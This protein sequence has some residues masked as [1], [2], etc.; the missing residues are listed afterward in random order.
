[1]I[2]QYNQRSA[3]VNREKK[4]LNPTWGGYKDQV[5][6][7]RGRKISCGGE[8]QEGATENTQIKVSGA[9]DRCVG[10]R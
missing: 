4:A 3:L 9:A 6:V 7:A 10:S 8:R 5:T 1:M 2:M